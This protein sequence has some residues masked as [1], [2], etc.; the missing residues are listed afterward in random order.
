MP[1]DERGRSDHHELADRGLH[2]LSHAKGHAVDHKAHGP[3]ELPGELALKSLEL[4]RDP[5]GPSE[6][7]IAST[8]HASSVPRLRRAGDFSEGS[9]P[10]TQ[11]TKMSKLSPGNNRRIKFKICFKFMENIHKP[12][13]T[14]NALH[15]FKK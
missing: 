14:F 6:D 4:G 5:R 2:V 12:L 9:G 7:A 13:F 1:A 8:A 10:K 3:R 11:A 15:F